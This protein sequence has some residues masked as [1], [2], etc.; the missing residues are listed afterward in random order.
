MKRDSN[1]CNKT[2]KVRNQKTDTASIPRIN[3]YRVDTELNTPSVLIRGGAYSG[4]KPIENAAENM[5]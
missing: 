2:F 5:L 3:K 1:Y 4:I